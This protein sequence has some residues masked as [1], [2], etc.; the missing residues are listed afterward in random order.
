M[1]VRPLPITHL[2]P[3]KLN[4]LVMMLRVNE[5]DDRPALIQGME[6]ISIQD[7][8]QIRQCLI[9]SKSYNVV[10]FQH[11]YYEPWF[12]RLPEDEQKQ[13]VFHQHQLFCRFVNI[14]ITIGNGKVYGGIVRQVYSHEADAPQSR[15]TSSGSR[16][17]VT[18][19]N[20]KRDGLSDNDDQRPKALGRERSCSLEELQEIR[21]TRRPQHPVKIPRYTFADAFCGIGG[22]SSGATQ[23]GLFV[24]WGLDRDA[25]AITGFSYNY[26][27]ATP[28]PMNADDLPALEDVKHLKVAILHLS[29]PCDYW[30]PNQ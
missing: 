12:W 16:A 23:A 6:D 2:V 4:E 5:H 19:N 24:K 1:L 27:E 18:H 30:S 17:S 14:E 13:I 9:T 26:P 28:L 21:R 10:N 29:P 15:G 7:V 11:N 8:A 25:A 3:D 22:A 20:T